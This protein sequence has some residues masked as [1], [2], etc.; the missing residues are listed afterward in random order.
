MGGRGLPQPLES[1]GP[2]PDELRELHHHVP[3]RGARGPREKGDGKPV[4]ALSQK[5]ARDERGERDARS[6]AQLLLDL[7]ELPHHQSLVRFPVEGEN[8]VSGEQTGLQVRLQRGLLQEGAESGGGRAG[9]GVGPGKEARRP[10]E[11]R[12]GQ[13]AAHL[14][15]S[16]AGRRQPGGYER[17]AQVHAHPDGGR[18]RQSPRREWPERCEARV[19]R[20]L[21][22]PGKVPERQR[23]LSQAADGERGAA[24]S[25]KDHRLARPPD[26]H[27]GDD[28][29]APLRPHHD[30]GRPGPRRLSHQGTGP[31]FL[32]AYVAVPASRG[33]IPAGV[34]DSDH[35]SDLCDPQERG[36]PGVF[37]FAGVQGV[38]GEGGRAIGPIAAGNRQ[39]VDRQVLQGTGHLHGRGS[40]GVLLGPREAQTPV[41]LRRKRPAEHGSRVSKGPGRS[42]KD[43]AHEHGPRRRRG[44]HAVA[45]VDH[46]F[47]EQG[48]GP[49]FECRQ[50]PL[51]PVRDRRH[52]TWAAEDP[53]LLL[54]AQAHERDQGGPVGRLRLRAQCV[55]PRGGGSGADHRQPGPR[56]RGKQQSQPLVP[57]GT[58]RYP[59]RGRKEQCQSPLHLHSAPGIHP[60]AVHG[61]RRPHFGVSGR[62]RRV[63]RA[64]VLR[65]RPSS[66][67]HER[68]GGHR[69]GV[70]HQDPVLSPPRHRARRT[71]GSEESALRPVVGH[72]HRHHLFFL[73]R[74]FWHAAVVPWFR[75]N[76]LSVPQAAAVYFL[77]Y[78]VL[79]KW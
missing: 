48:A 12:R 65:A 10:Q 63:H 64:G 44:P 29:S 24:Q 47:R 16:Q 69:N 36:P 71:R 74:Q 4:V 25:E 67:P 49:L 30:H 26:V 3:G 35:Q 33:R 15:D 50:R 2:F 62:G 32:R 13:K 38:G 39:K 75:G 61:G 43:L 1:G 78:R 14:R 21:S 27:P 17:L 73:V 68:G 9:R 46:G 31:E 8:D 37:H 53:L 76:H 41:H 23:R 66:S 28:L 60:F 58:V 19:L 79:W 34:R 59:R 7:R 70:E 51:H 22:P 40:Q 54:Q 42:K 11:A 20:R 57:R 6:A 18:F 77:R 45:T 5:A 55:S 56:F 52:E 72:G